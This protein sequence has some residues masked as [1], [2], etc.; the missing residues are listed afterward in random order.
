MPLVATTAGREVRR[1]RSRIIFMAAMLALGGRAV[2]AES[3]W[4][5]THEAEGAGTANVFDGGPPVTIEG[6]LTNPNV[7]TFVFGA[8][9]RTCA[10]SLCAR[11]SA[12]GE[13]IIS[14]RGDELIIDVELG[15]EYRPSLFG[16]DNP[17][18]TAEAFLSSVIEFVMPANKIDW[19]YQ[20]LIDEDDP[21]EGSTRIV[22][23]NVSRSTTL[24]TLT[25]Q[26]FST[27]G[28][29]LGGMGDVVR[30]T[31]TMAG[32][33]EIGPGSEREYDSDLT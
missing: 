16:G 12:S 9:D 18:G 5:W 21:F 7:G 20:L 25:T 6:P 8:T 32:M 19:F 10:G 27:R 23:E 11:A 13:L 24:L 30:I 14:T 3:I 17:G 29:P 2:R 31:S 15:A 28:M 22:V 4:M 33:G 1:G 26:V